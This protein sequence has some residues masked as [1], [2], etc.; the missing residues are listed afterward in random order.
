MALIVVGGAVGAL[1]VRRIAS[2]PAETVLYRAYVGLSLCG[3]GVMAL[4]SVSLYAVRI[5]MLFLALAALVYAIAKRYGR[6]D[7]DGDALRLPRPPFHL[8]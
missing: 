4:G 2:F 8:L 6:R 7:D 5:L 1:I 3:I